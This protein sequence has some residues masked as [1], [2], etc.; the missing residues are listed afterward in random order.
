[1]SLHDEDVRF[2]DSEPMRLFRV[3]GITRLT[4]EKDRSWIRISIARAFPVSDP[5][6]Y[7][8][9]L[10]GE[11]KEIGVVRDPSILDSESR[12]VLAGEL[13]LRYFVPSVRKVV[14]VK[15]EFGSVYFTLDTD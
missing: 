2:L 9:F 13:E 11:G 8:G 4:I 10:D 6:H 7:I 14:G 3:G 5:D 12:G 15:E 1:M